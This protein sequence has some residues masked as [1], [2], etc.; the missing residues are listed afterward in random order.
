MGHILKRRR[1]QGAYTP[2][3]MLQILSQLRLTALLDNNCM[4]LA[5]SPAVAEQL[6]KCC[7]G[8]KDGGPGTALEIMS[9][10]TPWLTQ[11]GLPVPEEENQAAEMPAQGSTSDT[12][13]IQAPAKGGHAG[14][15]PV[16][17]N[18]GPASTA[19][20]AKSSEQGPQ[21][22]TGT[23][24]TSGRP[25]G[26]GDGRQSAADRYQ[27]QGHAHVA[28]RLGLEES[29]FL[30]YVLGCLVVVEQAGDDAAGPGGQQACGLRQLDEQA[31]WT[32]CKAIRSN[33]VTSYVGYHHL[34][35]KGWLPRAGLLYGVDFVVYQMHPLAVHS[36][37]G[38]LLIPLEGPH[39]PELGWH[40][41][42]ITNRLITQVSKR[43][44][45][46]YVHE[47]QGGPDHST[48]ACL[49]SF[50]V[51]ERIVRRWVPNTTRGN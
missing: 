8:Q 16:P 37:F 19:E 14:T 27:V 39:R 42:Q 35:C 21:H 47:V 34:K 25:P 17:A 28:V 43:L 12:V 4:W 23:S 30:H 46:L 33:F 45:L 11:Q 44:M 9:V 50:T 49:D 36:E 22:Q 1:P 10:L 51:E 29:F 26:L 5:V 18:L 40:D 15:A 41:L 31:L 38:V 32:A 24:Y 20:P 3:Q 7:T 2:A 13:A 48:P 6:D